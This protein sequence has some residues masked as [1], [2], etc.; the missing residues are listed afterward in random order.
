MSFDVDWN[1]EIKKGMSLD[2]NEAETPLENISEGV[3]EF[4]KLLMKAGESIQIHGEKMLSIQY[5][6]LTQLKNQ[7]MKIFE[8]YGNMANSDAKLALYEFAYEYLLCYTLDPKKFIVRYESTHK[9]RL[10]SFIQRI[11]D[12]NNWPMFSNMSKTISKILFGGTGAGG[13]YFWWR[14][15]TGQALLDVATN[16]SKNAK[17]I[18]T[19]FGAFCQLAP[20]IISDYKTGVGALKP[21]DYQRIENTFSLIKEVFHLPKSFDV[22]NFDQAIQ[23]ILQ[24]PQGISNALV[25]FSFR[26]AMN[27]LSN[28]VGISQAVDQIPTNVIQFN[29][30]FEATNELQKYYSDVENVQ[31]LIEG[32]LPVDVIQGVAQIASINSTPLVA[33][34]D[35]VAGEVVGHIAETFSVWSAAGA[36]YGSIAAATQDVTEIAKQLTGFATE[37][38]NK[39]L[40]NFVQT[41]PETMKL[42]DDLT[43]V[44]NQMDASLSNF[45]RDVNERL[46][47]ATNL[48]LY[49][50]G[51][52]ACVLMFYM[53][54]SMFSFVQKTQKK[55][56]AS[57]FFSKGGIGGFKTFRFN[58]K[59]K[60]S[61]TKANP[62]KGSTRKTKS[63]SKAK[64]TS[65]TTGK[66]KA[67]SKKSPSPCRS[68]L[69]EKIRI[70]IKEGRY[71]STKQAIAVAYSQILKDHSE[72]N[73]EFKRKTTK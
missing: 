12:N 60:K 71:A 8:S 24:L 61:K 62:K 5:E 11:R 41:Q 56:A 35:E 20:K 15:T 64:A 49:V 7:A 40:E 70:N 51:V 26:T 72:C 67:S 32:R 53:I 48:S 13:A 34:T 9:P 10:E 16:A 58:G 23:G 55:R 38:T 27:K 14:S 52:I 37:K 31:A 69:S 42:Q 22:K 29:Q 65:T 57:S 19:H 68:M 59:V 36:I 54:Y 18:L 44:L 1:Y 25:T 43:T 39:A 50:F 33:A 2:A 28:V 73:K 63:E 30:A 21:Q 3:D 45:Q 46:P 4:T 66:A 17:D 6:E 47:A